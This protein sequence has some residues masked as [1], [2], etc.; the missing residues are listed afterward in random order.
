M[1]I[2]RASSTLRGLIIQPTI[3]DGDYT[4]EIFLQA[5][6][7][8]GPVQIV[9]GIRIA[10]ALPLPLAV[11][12]PALSHPRGPTHP[13]S[14]DVYWIKSICKERPSSILTLKIQGRTFHGLL[15]TGADTTCFT[16]LDWPPEWPLT[17]SPNPITGVTGAAQQVHLS[18]HRL[19]WQD[20][21]GDSG[22]VR[23]YVV[24]NLP[25]NLWGR[26]LMDQMGLVLLK[27]K[28]KKILDQMLAQGYVPSKG[29][30]K[31]L[32]G[33]TKPISAT[34]NPGRQ[35][36]GFSPSSDASQDPASPSIYALFQEPPSSAVLPSV[37]AAPRPSLRI[38]WSSDD[39]IWVAQ[40][41][42]TAEKLSAAAA[43]VQEQL[44]A[45]HIEPTTSP[46]NTPIFV[47]R[48]KSGSWRL[49]HDLRRINASMRPMG[50]TQ[51]GL[52]VPTAFPTNT[53]KIVLDLKDCFFFHP[54]RPC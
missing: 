36:L 38:S 28:D 11:E 51:P 22:L 44:A 47:I 12:L 6:A 2:G 30:G 16:P 33:I 3:V 29:L 13:G 43:L 1:I 34:P 54:F 14:S 40:W 8:Y 48:K 53:H 35:G 5:V 32:Q 24:P 25:I 20:S 52:P 46:W 27:C 26:D 17:P 19:L 23:P 50:A 4:G 45:G 41:P 49:L 10:Q 7:P 21:D 37:P 15:D 18:A 42:L 39:P 31:H 9:P